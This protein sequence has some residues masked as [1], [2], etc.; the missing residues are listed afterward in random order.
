MLFQAPPKQR[1]RVPKTH[2]VDG[3]R[4]AMSLPEGWLRPRHL[5]AY[6]TLVQ[7]LKPHF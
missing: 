2:A 4:I 7:Q 3:V 5:P 1:I 6:L